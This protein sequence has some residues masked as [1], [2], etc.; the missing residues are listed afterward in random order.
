MYGTKYPM[1]GRIWA[2]LSV[3]AAQ[4]VQVYEVTVRTGG[5]SEVFR[6]PGDISLKASHENQS[7]GGWSPLCYEQVLITGKYLHQR[8][9]CSQLL[10]IQPPCWLFLLTFTCRS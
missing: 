6:R 3:G 8:G 9:T 4:P 2:W 10:E 7:L 1:L 5:G